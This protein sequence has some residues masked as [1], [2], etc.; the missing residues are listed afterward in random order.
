MVIFSFGGAASLIFLYRWHVEVYSKFKVV[1][2]PSLLLLNR[3]SL[4]RGELEL[5]LP[6]LSVGGWGKIWACATTKQAEN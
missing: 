1:I 5:R 2:N 4:V 6:L 3:R